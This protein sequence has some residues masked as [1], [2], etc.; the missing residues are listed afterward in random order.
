[1]QTIFRTHSQKKMPLVKVTYA[2]G[3]FLES[4]TLEQQYID[5]LQNTLF[6]KMTMKIHIIIRH[7]L[8]S[9]GQWR[10]N[11]YYDEDIVPIQ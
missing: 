11:H 8:D 2:Q 9:E 4:G 6:K 1:M 7:L 3:L 10:R 5:V